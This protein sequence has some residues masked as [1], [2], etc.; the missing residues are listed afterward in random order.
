MAVASF[1]RTTKCLHTELS[2]E[3]KI[4]LI[5]ASKCLPKPTQ[6]QL[7][8]KFGIGRST[9]SNIPHKKV[10][11]R[12]VWENN[13]NAKRKRLNKPTQLSSLNELIYDFFCKARSK[14]TIIKIIIHKQ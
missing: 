8:D 1:R 12:D 2:L 13:Q 7:G 6:Q 14:V 3:K 4:A 5:C 11:Y 10:L 9:V